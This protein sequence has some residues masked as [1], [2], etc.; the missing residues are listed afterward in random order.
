MGAARANDSHGPRVTGK[1]LE[2]LAH[3]DVLGAVSHGRHLPPLH[4][5]CLGVKSALIPDSQTSLVQCLE[6]KPE[7]PG[8]LLTGHRKE[9]LGLGTLDSS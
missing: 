8:A 3:D 5:L 4:P 2:T 7:A 6:K 9:A 1:S